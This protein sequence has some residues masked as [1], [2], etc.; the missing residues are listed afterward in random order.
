M[1]SSSRRAAPRQVPAPEHGSALQ[2]S[3]TRFIPKEEL[4][5]F[6]SWTPGPLGPALATTPAS[7]PGAPRVTEPAGARATAVEEP[8]PDLEALQQAARQAGY[9]DGYRDGLAALESF[10]RSFAQQMASQVGELV[11]AMELQV[12]RL[13]ED[14][15]RTMIRSTIGLARQVVRSEVTTRPELVV[16]VARDSVAAI[17]AAARSIEMRLHPQDVE[18]VRAAMGEAAERRHVSFVADGS[19]SRGG[20]LVESDL[21]SVDATIEARWTQA[22]QRLGVETGEWDLAERRAMGEGSHEH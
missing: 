10:K 19:I 21:G 3:H 22:L 7:H 18:L 11:Q 6:A 15:A 12:D 17:T 4:A 5:G 1:N 8:A 2:P 13:D 16:Q 9:H 14:L 20:C